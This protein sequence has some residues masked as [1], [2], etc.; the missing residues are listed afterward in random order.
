[1]AGSGF[2]LS[3]HHGGVGLLQVGD[4]RRQRNQTGWGAADVR[5]PVHPVRV[6]AATAN[7][8]VSTGR[9]V[10]IIGSPGLIGVPVTM[11]GCM[12]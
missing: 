3:A 11:V 1:V 12:P 7:A 10:V 4:G 5:L 8:A 6:S 9:N 2:G